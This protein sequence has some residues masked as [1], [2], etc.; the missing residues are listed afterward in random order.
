MGNQAITLSKLPFNREQYIGNTYS[1]TSTTY[2][3]KSPATGSN[4]V[5]EAVDPAKLPPTIQQYPI[6][7]G[8]KVTITHA[9]VPYQALANGVTSPVHP[10]LRGTIKLAGQLL[11]NVNVDDVVGSTVPVLEPIEN[12]KNLLPK[13]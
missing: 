13:K 6:P 1:T 2:L 8:S 5:Q 7:S 10:Q 11:N 9:T 4:L 3:Q 12:S